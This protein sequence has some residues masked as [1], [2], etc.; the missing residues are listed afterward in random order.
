MNLFDDLYKIPLEEEDDILKSPLLSISTPKQIVDPLESGVNFVSKPVAPIKLS[1]DRQA[2]ILATQKAIEEVSLKKERIDKEISEKATT[3]LQ[4]GNI[5]AD[6]AKTMAT[7]SI[8]IDQFNTAPEDVRK[9]SISEFNSRH[10]QQIIDNIMLAGMDQ[11]D[12]NTSVEQVTAVAN[13]FQPATKK[14]VATPNGITTPAAIFANYWMLPSSVHQ[15]EKTDWYYMIV[16]KELRK[17]VMDAL[18]EGSAAHELI[19]ALDKRID[20]SEKEGNYSDLNYYNAQEFWNNIGVNV[21]PYAIDAAKWALGG[22]GLKT[23]LASLAGSTASTTGFGA[24]AAGLGAAAAGFIL[25]AVIISA[26]MMAYYGYQSREVSKTYTEYFRLLKNVDEGKYTFNQLNKA[27]DMGYKPEFFT[28]DGTL[29]TNLLTAAQNKGIDTSLPNGTFPTYTLHKYLGKG[30]ALMHVPRGYEYDEYSR[31]GDLMGEV[32]G[33]ALVTLP[34][35]FLDRRALV[36]KTAEKMALSVGSVYYTTKVAQN[37]ISQFAFDVMQGYTMQGLMS[38]DT[39]ADIMQM[40]RENALGF[41]TAPMLNQAINLGLRSIGHTFVGKMT[42]SAVANMALSKASKQYMDSLNVLRIAATAEM[43]AIDADIASDVFNKAVTNGLKVRHWADAIHSAVSPEGSSAFR[44]A[45]AKNKD[46]IEYLRKFKQEE[47]SLSTSKLGDPE[48]VAS[49][50]TLIKASGNSAVASSILE[51]DTLD[52]QLG[53]TIL[54]TVM[55]DSK[56][57]SSSIEK[58]TDMEDGKPVTKLGLFRTVEIPITGS[59][60]PLRLKIGV[61]DMIDLYEKFYPRAEGDTKVYGPKGRI[62]RLS[63]FEY[64]LNRVL[65]SEKPL[66]SSADVTDLIGRNR[67]LLTDMLATK[68]LTVES[69]EALRLN[70]VSGAYSKLSTLSD[71]VSDPDFNYVLSK[72]T[73]AATYGIGDIALTRKLL[74]VLNKL[75]NI[76]SFDPVLS[77]RFQAQNEVNKVSIVGAFLSDIMENYKTLLSTEVLPIDTRAKATTS[78]QEILRF[79]ADT[80]HTAYSSKQLPDTG[81]VPI[82]KELIAKLDGQVSEGEIKNINMTLYRMAAEAGD[83][84]SY[85]GIL[86][87][88]VRVHMGRESPA[89]F[90]SDKA[91]EPGADSNLAVQ[92]KKVLIDSYLTNNLMETIADIR[93]NGFGKIM[94]DLANFSTDPQFTS[95]DTV[96]QLNIK[97]MLGYSINTSNPS[98]LFKESKHRKE[99]LLSAMLH[100]GGPQTKAD[101]KKI[102]TFADLPPEQQAKIASEFNYTTLQSMAG[103]AATSAKLGYQL[104]LDMQATLSSLS[105]SSP[106]TIASALSKLHDIASNRAEGYE[107]ELTKALKSHRYAVLNS[108][109]TPRTLLTAIDTLT[110]AFHI[111]SESSNKELGLRRT[112]RLLRDRS[113]DIGN[114]ILRGILDDENGLFIHDISKAMGVGGSGWSAV[115]NS[116]SK[117]FKI[118]DE[119]GTLLSKLKTM[120]QFIRNLDGIEE[121]QDAV[122]NKL[123]SAWLQKNAAF[124]AQLE[125]LWTVLAG[126]TEASGITRALNEIGKT[127]SEVTGAEQKGS[128]IDYEM[129]MKYVI[130]TVHNDLFKNN[131]VDRSNENLKNSLFNADNKEEF[132]RKT[133]L[134]ASALE[135][136]V[137]VHQLYSELSDLAMSTFRLHM[138]GA[139]NGGPDAVLKAVDILRSLAGDT[140]E[141]SVK[142]QSII[143]SDADVLSKLASIEAETK[144]IVEAMLQKGILA[145]TLSRLGF[146]ALGDTRMDFLTAA[147]KVSNNTK[148]VP[149]IGILPNLKILTTQ[150]DTIREIGNAIAGMKNPL[151][152]EA[153]LKSITRAFNEFKETAEYFLGN[154]VL[155]MLGEDIYSALFY[156]ISR[157]VELSEAQLQKFHTEFTS[158]KLSAEQKE[159][160]R[161]YSGDYFSAALGYV[162]FLNDSL[163]KISNKLTA[164][165]EGQNG[166]LFTEDIANSIMSTFHSVGKQ[167]ITRLHKEN[168]QA[169]LLLNDN[170]MLSKPSRAVKQIWN[171]ISG[172]TLYNKKGMRNIADPYYGLSKEFVDNFRKVSIEKDDTVGRLHT[173]TARLG[174]DPKKPKTVHEFGRSISNLVT[175]THEGKFDVKKMTAFNAKFSDKIGIKITENSSPEDMLKA[176][177]YLISLINNIGVGKQ[178]GSIDDPVSKNIAVILDAFDKVGIL[179]TALEVASEFSVS[180]D[181]INSFSLK[182]ELQ[183]EK[184]KMTQTWE[185]RFRN[186]IVKAGKNP[187]LI[188]DEVRHTIRTTVGPE[189]SLE[190]SLVFSSLIITDFV[191]KLIIAAAMNDSL[192]DYTSVT[193][194]KLYEGA[195]QIRNLADYFNILSV[196]YGG[197]GTEEVGEY[198]RGNLFVNTVGTEDTNYTRIVNSPIHVQTQKFAVMSYVQHAVSELEYTIRNFLNDFKS[199]ATADELSSSTET[200]YLVQLSDLTGGKSQNILI[201]IPVDDTDSVMAITK[202][203]LFGVIEPD[204]D[205]PFIFMQT[206]QAGLGKNKEGGVTY[207]DG[208]MT[209]TRTTDGATVVL[210]KDP[211]VKFGTTFNNYQTPDDLAKMVFKD[212]II[213]QVSNSSDALMSE[214]FK[215]VEQQAGDKG[216]NTAEIIG[217][218][219][220]DHAKP[221]DILA[222][223]KMCEHSNLESQREFRRMFNDYMKSPRFQSKAEANSLLTTAGAFGKSDNSPVTISGLNARI[224]TANAESAAYERAAEV[225]LPKGAVLTKDLF[226]AEVYKQKNYGTKL[227]MYTIAELNHK[228]WG[229][230]TKSVVPVD[231]ANLETWY[232]V[233]EQYYAATKAPRTLTIEGVTFKNVVRVMDFDNYNVDRAILSNKPDI[234]IETLVDGKRT[235]IFLSHKAVNADFLDS[236]T[237]V[238]KNDILKSVLLQGVLKYA[239]N[240]IATQ[241]QE[242]GDSY[243]ENLVKERVIRILADSY[244]ITNVVDGLQLQQILNDLAANTPTLARA[245]GALIKSSDMVQ[246]ASSEAAPFSRM[247]VANLLNDIRDALINTAKA[248]GKTNVPISEMLKDDSFKDSVWQQLT[249]TNSWLHSYYTIQDTPDKF[250]DLTKKF[251]AKVLLEGEVIDKTEGKAKDIVSILKTLGDIDDPH[252]KYQPKAKKRMGANYKTVAMSQI[253]DELVTKSFATQRS[254]IGNFDNS[255]APLLA[256]KPNLFYNFQTKVNDLIQNIQVGSF[257]NRMMF[258]TGALHYLGKNL[259]PREERQFREDEK[260]GLVKIASLKSLQNEL[261]YIFPEFAKL[262]MKSDQF[263][264]ALIEDLYDSVYSS[265][266]SLTAYRDQD[267]SS[268]SVAADAINRYHKAIQRLMNASVEEGEFKVV[269]STDLYEQLSFLNEKMNP[270]QAS[271]T[272]GGQAL[273][274]INSLMTYFTT[275]FSGSVLIQNPT[276]WFRNIFGAFLQSSLSTG[277]VVTGISCTLKAIKDILAYRSGK[278]SGSYAEYLQDNKPKPLT[279]ARY[280]ITPHTLDMS[281]LDRERYAAFKVMHTIINKPL[282]I[283]NS[284]VYKT[285]G[286]LSG[287]DPSTLEAK[288]RDLYGQIDNMTRYAL[289]I[290]AKEGKARAPEDY[291]SLSRLLSSDRALRKAVTKAYSSDIIDSITSN[292]RYLAPMSN[293]DASAYARKFSFVYDELPEA[294]KLV[295]SIWNPFVS[296]TYNSYRILYNSMATYPARVASLYLAMSVIN[297]AVMKDGLGIDVSF[298]SFIPN[299]DVF[300]W[301]YGDEDNMNFINVSNPSAPFIRFARSVMSQRDPYTKQDMSSFGTH[302]LWVRSYMNSFLPVSPILNFFTRLGIAKGKEILGYEDSP[303]AERGVMGTLYSLLPDSYI[304]KRWID[305]G[306]KGKPI[307]KFGTTIGPLAGWLYGIAGINMRPTDRVKSR[308]MI[309]TFERTDKALTSQIENLYQQDKMRTNKDVQMEIRALEKRREENARRTVGAFNDV[310]G[311]VPQH[312]K[313]NYLYNHPLGY[314]EAVKDYITEAW[315]NLLS[316]AIDDYGRKA[317]Y[318]TIRRD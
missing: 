169:E 228:L 313:D 197:V 54:T 93:D 211:N 153:S 55:D 105:G 104:M 72:A 191:D 100:K 89:L 237:F 86:S 162:N 165:A 108:T 299:L 185:A 290:A 115:Y 38:Y 151:D 231:E 199:N 295:R 189:V 50:K 317:Y 220:L 14:F 218:F 69:L 280:G 241:L 279:M 244:S 152:I 158:P 154:K 292:G 194:P 281:T 303:F 80:L 18:E 135:S 251:L 257:I 46:R 316:L 145:D 13:V 176:K 289:W 79:V 187:D 186:R 249:K 274:V 180:K 184:E 236:S 8:Q 233:N 27:F 240:S 33:T 226:E 71:L 61:D 147:K 221:R 196:K 284:A 36:K 207:V 132:T 265:K 19:S 57:L 131:I 62:E 101:A 239:S 258:D 283:L 45:V 76:L 21:V 315:R 215:V 91:F 223:L 65:L 285:V 34:L 174:L 246:G 4:A 204:E 43:A 139:S 219:D 2:N 266:K 143:G 245:F 297:N 64:S 146:G 172:S 75:T 52:P 63:N 26:G 276:S 234:V 119:E 282:E 229:A 227:E 225:T 32:V 291:S 148:N 42:N 247:G 23:A 90:L 118:S 164:I 270:K 150:L 85:R 97:N 293:A 254:M 129:V 60:V 29:N 106:R 294:W 209:V 17:S 149:L 134:T 6:K 83:I 51:S 128:I 224:I 288:A 160:M 263:Q 264:A 213:I 306:I 286:A 188:M 84:D 252:F 110:T 138:S 156:K 77:K 300:S 230:D 124:R 179:D 190:D 130:D 47:L 35:A 278:E 155:Y 11:E 177:T 214:A 287:K 260:N 271:N 37:I 25:P 41:V 259:S 73:E 235:P 66:T 217:N 137:R 195:M 200:S 56:F 250:T 3:I 182:P 31:A 67:S 87:D 175:F 49:L 242:A 98:S 192:L 301:I 109:N 314:V 58:F 256:L 141:L 302:E 28:S 272:F 178:I 10:H 16:N 166:M 12:L 133:H 232:K 117:F 94:R 107:D 268:A 309:D 70:M 1:E 201:R 44:A 9:R 275:N 40:M 15:R 193:M 167:T 96:G 159:V 20:E 273:E 48:A 120:D 183:P 123:R 24:T 206:G 269:M 102:I 22:V 202:R 267:P 262:I 68:Q 30:T 99:R 88:L 171:A 212:G 59:R 312:I 203:A 111:A 298:D 126:P 92:L 198:N 243:D 181:K 122:G 310:F 238:Q 136:I 103:E 116:L 255:I 74:P 81:Y 305:E 168:S 308:M 157:S 5:E 222:F 170:S 142:L 95:I 253:I 163:V 296:F 210:D 144:L 78:M 112:I 205:K 113:I 173:I 161:S 140:S 125:S 261:R 318:S 216:L 39:T 304:Y 208:G 277:D 307:D 53:R 7:A 114:P 121:V 311:E 248:V 127:L 82:L